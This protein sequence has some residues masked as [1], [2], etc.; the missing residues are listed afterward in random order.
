[1]DDEKQTSHQYRLYTTKANLEHAEG[2]YYDVSPDILQYI[3]TVICILGPRKNF[4]S[5]N[6]NCT[7]SLE[8]NKLLTWP[9]T[10]SP[11]IYVKFVTLIPHKY[12]KISHNG[13]G[14][15]LSVP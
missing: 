3:H 13:H 15:C 9:S 12:T 6:P 14:K 7:R 1:M 5:P 2:L 4:T 11:Y 8:A 10:L